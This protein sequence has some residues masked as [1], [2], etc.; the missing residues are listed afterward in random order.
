MKTFL[1]FP[2][3]FATSGVGAGICKSS[4]ISVSAKS[5]ES[6]LAAAKQSL[7]RET[8]DFASFL[9]AKRLKQKTPEGRMY[10]K[11][12][13]MEEKSKKRIRRLRP[14]ENLVRRVEA[15]H[16]EKALN[17]A[18]THCEEYHGNKEKFQEKRDKLTGMVEDNKEELRE[19][20]QKREEMS[21][22]EKKLPI[23]YER[24]RLLR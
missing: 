10:Q 3:L 21:A 17:M 24:V 11:L 1:L 14:T 23:G 20:I 19:I 13:A 2:T 6:K 16:C 22:E 18:Q 9:A 15:F 7:L 12:R 8:E 5:T 4:R